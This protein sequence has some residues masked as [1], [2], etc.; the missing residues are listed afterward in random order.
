MT[1][2]R[3]IK[4]QMVSVKMTGAQLSRAQTSGG[5]DQNSCAAQSLIRILHADCFSTVNYFWQTEIVICAD[6]S[7]QMDAIF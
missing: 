4:A 3:M 2:M 5:S 6:S 1:G 7:K